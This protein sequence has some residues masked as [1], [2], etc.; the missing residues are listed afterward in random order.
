MVTCPS[1]DTLEQAHSREAVPVLP[2]QLQLC[3]GMC[4]G[5]ELAGVALLA[6]ACPV[7][8]TQQVCSDPECHFTATNPALAER[9]VDT[10]FNIISV[11]IR[12]YLIGD[13]KLQDL[14]YCIQSG[15]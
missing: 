5:E 9:Y 2:T 15:V 11:T 8:S 13:Y 14:K 10:Y 7:Q 1:P 3:S 12:G 4:Q 6:A